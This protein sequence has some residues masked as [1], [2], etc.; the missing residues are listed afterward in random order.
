VGDHI[1]VLAA[2][3]DD[4]R[5]SFDGRANYLYCYDQ[6]GLFLVELY[7]NSVKTEEHMVERFVTLNY[8][9]FD[10]FV[11][12]NKSGVDN[13]I[14]I[15]TGP[16][17]YEA[18]QDRA[19]VNVNNEAGEIPVSIA[20]TV[21]VTLDENQLAVSVNTSSVA[22]GANVLADIE[23][24]AG[25]TVSVLPSNENRLEA[26]IQSL[27]TNPN[28]VRIAPH[29]SVS[30]NKGEELKAGGSA[31]YKTKTHIYVYNGG[32]QSVYLARNE[33]EVTA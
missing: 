13:G 12:I 7:K 30:A 23:V 21:S 10:S 1:T 6:D 9:D 16:G 27:S 32:T 28:A 4:A 18:S 33:L 22:T 25:Q 20:D 31:S 26:I 24:P 2:S 17:T 3:G 5:K 15:F 29:S 19:V 8:R 11:V 14:R